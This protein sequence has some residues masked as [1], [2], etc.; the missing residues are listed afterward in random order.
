M[1]GLYKYEYDF[2]YGILS[3]VFF[4]SAEYVEAAKENPIYLGEMMGKY[5][6]VVISL[7]DTNI[8]LIT[9]DP[10]QVEMLETLDITVGIN[11]LL[12]IEE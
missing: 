12:Y 1:R 11:P 8:T 3:G 4:A 9:D 2:N 10:E 5:S 6:D 7:D